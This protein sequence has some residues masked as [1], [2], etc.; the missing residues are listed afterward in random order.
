M[1]TE[2][3]YLAAKK[4]VMDY[5]EAQRLLKD[6][7]S[8][9]CRNCN[10]SGNISTIGMPIGFYEQCYACDGTGQKKTV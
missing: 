8:D 10:G 1:I 9:T 5:E 6:N 2:S 4:L 7:A 3:T